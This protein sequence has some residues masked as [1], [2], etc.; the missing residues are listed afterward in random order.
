M[1][2]LF[3]LEN[4][5][6][7]VACIGM[8]AA[9]VIDGWIRKVPNRLTFPLIISGWLLGLLHNFD[10]HP[11]AGIGGIGASLACTF[12]GFLLLFFPWA[13]N[14]MGAGDVKMQ[15][16]FGAWIGSFFGLSMGL[17]V[18]VLAFCVGGII[19]GLIAIGMMIV[20]RSYRE[21]LQNMRLILLDTMVSGRL[22]KV[23]DRG[24][25][26]RNKG[27]KLPYGIPLCIGFVG[28][29]CYLYY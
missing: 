7:F 29:L 2:N 28:Y 4:W 8:I 12:M 24:Q 9:G 23:A 20:N 18:V 10:V 19:G 1:E 14:M 13:F 22:A 21:N 3:K 11:D 26:I 6:L 27:P 25:E 16:G 5:P 17:Y 15:M